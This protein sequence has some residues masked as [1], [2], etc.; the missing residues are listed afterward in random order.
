MYKY[1]R[2]CT[3]IHVYIK[4]VATLRYKCLG[5]T[6]WLITRSVLRSKGLEPIKDDKYIVITM[7]LDLS[8]TMYTTNVLYAAHKFEVRSYQVPT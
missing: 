8:D 1:P 6:S 4:L 2:V 5:S 7:M 3:Y